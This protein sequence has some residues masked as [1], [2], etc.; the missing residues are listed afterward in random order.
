M[1]KTHRNVASSSSAQMQA[2]VHAVSGNMVAQPQ[3]S[4]SKAIKKKSLLNFRAIKNNYVVKP[5]NTGM[6]MVEND[7]PPSSKNSFMANSA[8]A[9]SHANG[10][11]RRNQGKIRASHSQFSDDHARI[12]NTGYM[13]QRS[14][15]AAN[16]AHHS[17][18][19]SLGPVADHSDPQRQSF[20]Y[21]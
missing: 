14:S 11:S 19:G 3:Q 9:N 1:I 16:N 2:E 13:S 5:T 15:G 17:G 7:L 10:G 20:A 18:M 21:S 8:M 12:T 4:P 6:S